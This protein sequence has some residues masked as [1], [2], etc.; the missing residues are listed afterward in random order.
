MTKLTGIKINKRKKTKKESPNIYKLESILLN[1]LEVKDNMKRKI[2]K[3]FE[4]NKNTNTTNQN[5]CNVAK[6]L[7]RGKFRARNACIRREERSGVSNLNFLRKNLENKEQFIH[8][9]SSRKEV[10]NRRIEFTKYKI[11]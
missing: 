3:H 2:R 5:L 11:D 7:I 6:M 10:I 8:Y 9:V 1:N 4:Q